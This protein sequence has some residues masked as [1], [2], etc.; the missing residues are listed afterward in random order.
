MS[1]F[2]SSV[3]GQFSKSLIIGALFPVV[4]FLFLFT[5]FVEPFYPTPWNQWGFLQPIATLETEWR[6]LTLTIAVLSLS[7][8]LFA[9]NTAIVRLYEGYPWMNSA[10]GKWGKQ[11]HEREWDRL[12]ARWLGLRTLLRH[13][14]REPYRAKYSKEDP[15]IEGYWQRI[16]VSYRASYPHKA[17]LLLPTELG[18]IIRSFE[19]YPS[20]QYNIDAVATWPRLVA[21]IP[22]GYG[23]AIDEAR[24]TFTLIINGSLLSGL[25]AILLLAAEFLSPRVLFTID[26]WTS[27]EP[28]LWL[29]GTAEFTALSYLCYRLSLAP[30]TA[31]GSVVKGAFDLYR[32]DLL[33]S[34]G[35]TTQPKSRKAERALWHLLTSQ[36]IYGDRPEGPAPDYEAVF[37]AS[38]PEC[39]ATNMPATG[40]TLDRAALPLTDPRQLSVVVV[41]RY[42]AQQLAPKAIQDLVV[43][44]KVEQAW[45]VWGSA[46]ADGAP[47][48]V[49][50]TNPYEFHLGDLDP[51]AER[52]LTYTIIRERETYI[53]ESRMPFAAKVRRPPA[54]FSPAIRRPA[55]PKQ[56]EGE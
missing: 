45:L 4:I 24:T 32:W 23:Q 26:Y 8:V 49:R 6:V 39:R 33:K 18:N 43:T 47:I 25:L 38:Y 13:L 29:L 20:R 56:Q 19:A 55:K 48:E 12:D 21:V 40:L 51:G 53:S 37:D 31:W 11:R 44:D 54:A 7:M 22:E 52:T 16:G 1:G 35:Y 41:I 10:A 15:T 42:P 17:G 28:W 3:S 27:Q 14:G 9:F 34:L 30:A 2:L 5:A 46:K 36:L 50:G